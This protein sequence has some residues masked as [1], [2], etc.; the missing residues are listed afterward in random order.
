MRLHSTPGSIRQS[1]VSILAVI[2]TILAIGGTVVLISFGYWRHF[3]IMVLVTP[4]LLLRTER[5]QSLGLSAFARGFN[6][7]LQLPPTVAVILT[8]PLLILGSLVVKIASTVRT[9]VAAPIDSL[10]EIPKNW[11]LQVLCVDSFHPPELVPGI[12][13]SPD[14]TLDE[15]KISNLRLTLSGLTWPATILFIPS[16]LPAYALSFT[17]RMTLKGTSI[18]WAPLLWIVP[19]FKPNDSLVVRLKRINKSSRGRCTLVLSAFVI[20]G[21]LAKLL[22]YNGAIAL[23]AA[24]PGPFGKLLVDYIAPTTLPLWQIA[25]ILNSILAIV[26]FLWSGDEIIRLEDQTSQRSSSFPD[27]WLRSTTVIRNLLSVYTSTCL[28]YLTLVRSQVIHL[29][30]LDEKLFPWQ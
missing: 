25:S 13:S 20:V 3:W 5:S 24:V 10:T 18:V 21:F 16:V 29:P 19:K 26:L 8:L 2:E 12:E 15:L 1:E 11:F 4:L 9:V 30:P 17:Y 27:Y 22:I 14:K 6:L 23:S 7:W 28:A